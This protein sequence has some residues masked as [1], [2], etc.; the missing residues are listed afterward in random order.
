MD[1]GYEPQHLWKIKLSMNV[2]L[3]TQ[4]CQAAISKNKEMILVYPPRSNS[5][6]AQPLFFFFR[7]KFT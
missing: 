6:A 7:G 2:E 5:K 3:C 4:L 1:S